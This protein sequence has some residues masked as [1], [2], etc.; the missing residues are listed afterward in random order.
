MFLV[1]HAIKTRGTEV[2][3]LAK[4]QKCHR[5]LLTQRTR[6]VELVLSFPGSIIAS[7]ALVF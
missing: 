2:V 4:Y 5:R 6:K 7:V 1:D 3:R